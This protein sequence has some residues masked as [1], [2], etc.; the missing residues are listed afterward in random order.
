[1]HPTFQEVAQRLLS[2]SSELLS[3]KARMHDTTD[4]SPKPF[5]GM[6]DQAISAL[7]KYSNDLENRIVCRF[8]FCTSASDREGMKECASIMAKLNKEKILAQV[9]IPYTLIQSDGLMPQRYICSRPMFIDVKEVQM[10]QSSSLALMDLQVSSAH[11]ICQEVCGK[12]AM[13]RELHWT[14]KQEAQIIEAVFPSSQQAME[15][16]LQRYCTS[17]LSLCRWKVFAVLN[18]VMEQRVRAA[19]DLILLPPDRDA[20]PEELRDFVRSATVKLNVQIWTPVI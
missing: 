19:L 6:L 1:M 12:Q 15:L 11:Q 17:F 8:D 10:G 7:E 13:Y 16:F 4:A 14:V 20:E 2:V 9:R 18:R 3:A 5:A